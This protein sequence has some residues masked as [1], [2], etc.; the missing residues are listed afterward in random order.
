PGAN[1]CVPDA[2]GDA[3]ASLSWFAS[4]DDHTVQIILWGLVIKAGKTILIGHGCT[5]RLTRAGIESHITICG[6]YTGRQISDP[7]TYLVGHL[8]NHDVR[9][10][11]HQ[12]HALVLPVDIVGV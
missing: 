8:L 7:N 3:K 4:G 10:S 1:S 12:Q 5:Q 2:A 6:R 9:I 11:H